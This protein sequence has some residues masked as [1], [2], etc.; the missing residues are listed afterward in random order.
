MICRGILYSSTVN[1]RKEHKLANK[2]YYWL[3]LKE[4]FFTDKRIKRLRRIAGGDTYTIIYL[5]ML[6]LSLQDEG[7]LFFEQ[8]ED[9]FVS[10]LALTIDEDDDNV[11]VTLSFLQKQG[12]LDI[13]E[14]NEYFLNEI[15]SM[16]GSETASTRRSRKSREQK[17]LQCNKMQQNGNGELELDK[18]L[19]KDIDIECV[20]SNTQKLNS[21]NEFQLPKKIL[22]DFKLNEKETNDIINAMKKADKLNVEYLESKIQ[23]MKDRDKDIKDDFG[24]FISMLK[25]DWTSSNKS[26]T[27]RKKVNTQF[28]N[29][30][31]R[32]TGEYSDE[33]LNNLLRNRSE[34]KR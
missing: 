4:D 24:Y 34:Q 6:L 3:K 31:Q 2:R 1:Y 12:L 23:L 28:H 21:F 15:P 10:E 29:F 27:T 26:K 14:K 20:N 22:S 32:N 11:G 30:K 9:D 18:E 25:N 13:R 17:A 16:I 7:S 33:A 19:D 8:V 5:K